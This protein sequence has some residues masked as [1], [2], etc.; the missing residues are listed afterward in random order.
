[1]RDR[2]GLDASYLGGPF[3]RQVRIDDWDQKKIEQQA[4]LILGVGGLG[5]IVALNLLR[6]GVGRIFLIDYDVVDIH[7]LNR[8]L[9]FSFEDVGKSKVESAFKNAAFHNTGKTQIEYFHGNALTNWEVVT[10]FARRSTFVYNCIDW[11]DKFDA[12]VSALCLQLKI[13]LVMGGTFAVS[14]TVDFYP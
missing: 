14:L 12:A 3:D 9:L 4:V 13:P 11:G 8:Q 10:N 5:S 7:N 6:L 1:M 2:V